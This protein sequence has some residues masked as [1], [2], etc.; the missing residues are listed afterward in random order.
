MFLHAVSSLN[1]KS[2]FWGAWVAQSV[3][4]PAWLR[5]WRHGSWVRAPHR[6]VRS[7]PLS[8]SLSVPLL[9]VRSFSL[10]VKNKWAL[11]KNLFIVVVY[12]IEKHTSCNRFWKE[13]FR[14]MGHE[15]QTAIISHFPFRFKTGF[16]THHSLFLCFRLSDVF[17]LL[18]PT[19][20]ILLIFQD[21]GQ[22]YSRKPSGSFL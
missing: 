19:V 18:F 2:L 4:C 1:L 9:L 17:S 21:S 7:T 12:H 13:V 14:A 20:W 22:L 8:A 6:A 3:K 11:K 5:S 16:A 10:S 15:G